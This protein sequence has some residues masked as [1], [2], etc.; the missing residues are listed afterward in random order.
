MPTIPSIEPLSSMLQFTAVDIN[1]NPQLG[2][3]K[4]IRNFGSLNTYW[5]LHITVFSS[6]L[7]NPYE[8]RINI[9]TVIYGILLHWNNVSWYNRADVLK[10]SPSLWEYAQTCTSLSYSKPQLRQGMEKKKIPL[11]T[12]G[13]LFDCIGTRAS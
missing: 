8:R 7:R 12:K 6:K 1:W 5:D 13:L 11:L 9:L 4:R 3:E 10:K 2:N